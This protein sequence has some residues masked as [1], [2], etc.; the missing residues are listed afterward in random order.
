M[1]QTRSMLWAAA[2]ATIAPAPSPAAAAAN[3]VRYLGTWSISTAT[4]ASGANSAVRDLAETR[5]LL[6]KRLTF[7]RAAIIAPRPLACRSPRYA[8]KGY[9]PGMLFQ[10]TLS[11]PGRQATA[12][13]F[14]RP[15]TPTLETGCD[16]PIDFHFA[17]G[18]TAMFELDDMIYTIRRDR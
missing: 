3:A 15:T 1:T 18:R 2:L 11:D 13:G 6:G 10:G 7:T 16:G 8:I 5:R 9:P 12:L 17:N 14:T 4:P